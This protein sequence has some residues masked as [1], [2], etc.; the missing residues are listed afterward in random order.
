MSEEKIVN[1]YYQTNIKTS[2]NEDS[3][4][5][6][7]YASQQMLIDKLQQENRQL[8]EQIKLE[9]K[10][11]DENH[12]YLHNQLDLYKSVLDEIREHTKIGIS[13]YQNGGS[14]T[15]M[16]EVFDTINEILDKVKE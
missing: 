1:N 16:F 6:M 2:R 9:V 14:R 10:V 7:K 13:T 12:E 4:Y 15:A 5:A 8:K 3:V 11:R